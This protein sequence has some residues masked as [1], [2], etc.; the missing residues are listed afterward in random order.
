MQAS[1]RAFQAMSF[2]GAASSL[3]AYVDNPNVSEW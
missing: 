3:D 1:L 2:G